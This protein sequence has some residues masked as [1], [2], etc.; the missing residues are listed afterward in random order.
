MLRKPTAPLQ[1][2]LARQVS[3]PARAP[4]SPFLAAGP[5]PAWRTG[6][7]TQLETTLRLNSLIR[8][9]FPQLQAKVVRPPG[10]SSGWGRGTP[11]AL[12]T[13]G[14]TATCPSAS[15]HLHPG[16]PTVCMW[17]NRGPERAR[18]SCQTAQQGTGPWVLLPT[19]DTGVLMTSIRGLVPRGQGAG[20][21]PGRMSVVLPKQLSQRRWAWQK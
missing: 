17:G 8:I 10:W 7:E 20:R 11:R 18:N 15:T 14:Q 13:Q 1:R 9:D 2:G 12:Q 19:Q 21:G 3:G 6:G 16:P 4:T 5:W